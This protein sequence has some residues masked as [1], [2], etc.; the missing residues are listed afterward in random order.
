MVNF[1]IFWPCK[2]QVRVF[3]HPKAS[4]F[5]LVMWWFIIY[6]SGKEL[7]IS[8]EKKQLTV[9]AVIVSG[10]LVCPR[11]SML[12]NLFISILAF[13]NEKDCLALDR[14][15]CTSFH[16]WSCHKCYISWTRCFCKPNEYKTWPDFGGQNKECLNSTWHQVIE[17][18][19][20]NNYSKNYYS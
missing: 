20:C 9:T 10:Q 17:L 15:K 3:L 13:V 5:S 8:L 4:C 6:T 12:V 19:Y 7:C 1:R 14:V 16:L 2:T 11:V 18:L